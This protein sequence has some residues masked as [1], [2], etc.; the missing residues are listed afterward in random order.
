MGIP[1]VSRVSD[2]SDIKLPTVEGPDSNTHRVF[3]LRH[4]P[5]QGP[6]LNLWVVNLRTLG[7]VQWTGE[8]RGSTE[9]VVPLQSVLPCSF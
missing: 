8:D 3:T 9:G 7:P 4:P 1:P 5:Y 2:R 6:T